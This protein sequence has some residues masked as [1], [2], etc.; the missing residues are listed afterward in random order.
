MMKFGI[1]P[2]EDANYYAESL[3]QVELA[4][5]LGF[6]SVWLEEHHPPVAD[7][8]AR[9]KEALRLM[10]VIGCAAVRPPLLP[11]PPEEVE[12]LHQA[13]IAAGLLEAV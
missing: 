4:E 8:R 12:A 3:R 11:L 10:G 5:N 13:L 9:T 6:D 2:I 1:I 7:Y